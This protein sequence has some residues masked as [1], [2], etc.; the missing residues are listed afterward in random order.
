MTNLKTLLNFSIN[1]KDSIPSVEQIANK[2]QPVDENSLRLPRSFAHTMRN[3]LENKTQVFANNRI[4]SD[5]E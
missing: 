4:K 1:S 2:M 3:I 5:G